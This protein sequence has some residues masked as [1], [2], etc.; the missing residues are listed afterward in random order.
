MDFRTI[1]HQGSALVECDFVDPELFPERRKNPDQ[2]FTDGSGS[3]HVDNFFLSHIPHLNFCCADSNPRPACDQ[4]ITCQMSLTF[5]RLENP[6]I[7]FKGS[8][9]YGKNYNKGEVYG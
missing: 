4:Q 8:H 1:G 7:V 5:S 2:R 3:D 6:V 9:L